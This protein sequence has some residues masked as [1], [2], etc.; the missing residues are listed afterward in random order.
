M[1]IRV[2]LVEDDA[3]LGESL[4]QRFELEGVACDWLRGGRPAIGRIRS[5][6]YSLVLS[7]IRLP[8]ITGAEMFSELQRTEPYLPP[9]LFITG[10]GNVDEAVTLLKCGASDYVRKP[11]DLDALLARIRNVAVPVADASRPPGQPQ[12]GVS[13]AMRKIEEILPKLSRHVRTLLITGASGVGKEV[14]ARRIHDLDTRDNALPFVA[15]NCAGLAESLLEAELFGFEKG[16]FTGAVRTR[17]GVFEQAEGGTLF[18]D[19]IG[20]MPMSMQ[21]K[22]LRAVQDRLITRIGGEKPIEV[23]VRLICATHR[24]LPEMVAARAFREDLYY[25]IN[26]VQL[27]IPALKDRPEDIPW[28]ARRFWDEFSA[29]QRLGLAYPGAALE[30]QLMSHDWPGNARELKHVVE[31]SC[32]FSEASRG[33]GMASEFLGEVRSHADLATVDLKQ[34]SL[35]DYVERCERLLVI[36]RLDDFNWQ[37]TKTAQSLG[38]T[39]KSLWER[40]KRLGVTRQPPDANEAKSAR[41]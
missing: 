31:R 20:D 2:C 19:E 27:R 26:T 39:R 4:M 6:A 17:R 18:L 21:A 16:A 13:P 41:D 38:I 11:F 5:N 30:V 8:D 37:I 35:G 23:H 29:Q 12:L 10:F 28:L 14:V 40:M 32:L 1:S 34:I 15:V 22:V 3:I 33:I 36:Q 7:D 25:R 24:N 9:F